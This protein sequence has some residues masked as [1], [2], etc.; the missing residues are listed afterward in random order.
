M[1][2]KQH[3]LFASDRPSWSIFR[4]IPLYLSLGEAIDSASAASMD[5]LT[6]PIYFPNSLLL[7]GKAQLLVLLPYCLSLE[8]DWG[9]QQKCDPWGCSCNCT[10]TVESFSWLL[11]SSTTECWH[12]ISLPTLKKHLT[13]RI[14]P[15]VACKIWTAKKLVVVN[16]VFE[17]FGKN[18]PSHHLQYFKGN[19]DNKLLIS[20]F[21]N[22]FSSHMWLIV[23]KFDI[24][25]SK[26]LIIV[27]CYSLYQWSCL[28]MFFCPFELLW[29]GMVWNERK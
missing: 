14:V 21:R 28:V 17:H 23:S 4:T 27:C 7:N 22:T 29:Y 9:Q 16:I 20:T 18:N 19:N 15:T 2:S 8:W 25:L 10:L 12:V 24:K 5:S 6:S 3:S 1:L 11:I 26:F 13:V